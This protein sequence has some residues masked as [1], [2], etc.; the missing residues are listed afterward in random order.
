MW[1]YRTLN[2]TVAF[3]LQRL[4][5]GKPEQQY[6]DIIIEAQEPD[7]SAMEKLGSQL[8]SETKDVNVFCLYN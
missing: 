6:G 4:S 8:L 5:E 7:W 2:M 1:R 3:E